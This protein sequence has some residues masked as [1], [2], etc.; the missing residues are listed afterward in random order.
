[1]EQPSDTFVPVEDEFGRTSFVLVP[2]RRAA[3]VVLP[4]S[5]APPTPVFPDGTEEEKARAISNGGPF[6][7]VS[8]GFRVG[9]YTSWDDGAKWAVSGC[10]HSSSKKLDR[11]DYFAAVQYFTNLVKSNQVV[12]VRYSM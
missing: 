9:V 7:V 12:T 6:Y 10:S 5:T 1:M 4:D 2:T 8:V 11:T 3:P